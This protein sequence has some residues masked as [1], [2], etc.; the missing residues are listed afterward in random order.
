MKCFDNENETPIMWACGIGN[1]EN[2]QILR[3][4]GAKFTAEQK[5]KIMQ[6]RSAAV[7]SCLLLD[8]NNTKYCE[9]SCE[10]PS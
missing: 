2:E 8:Q 4:F 7:T 9:T 5:H 10:I 6:I 1:G 3:E